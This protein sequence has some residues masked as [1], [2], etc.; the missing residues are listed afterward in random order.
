MKEVLNKLDDDFMKTFEKRLGD[1]G[2]FRTTL[3]ENIKNLEPRDQYVVL[4]AG[5]KK[6][7]F[8][9]LWV[10]NCSGFYSSIGWLTLHE[11]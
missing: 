8:C 1:L 10:N 2:E 5:I 11:H 7:T 9:Q 6:Y 4:V 3:E